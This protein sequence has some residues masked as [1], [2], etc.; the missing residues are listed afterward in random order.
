MEYDRLKPV[1]RAILALAYGISED[2]LRYKLKRENLDI[3]SGTIFPKDIIRVI[4]KLGIPPHYEL[5]LEN[6]A[7]KP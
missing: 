7:P 2:V 1:T 4:E 3:P 5:L 6:G